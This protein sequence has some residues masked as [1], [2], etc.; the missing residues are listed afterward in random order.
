MGHTAGDVGY[1]NDGSSPL[2]LRAYSAYERA[3]LTIV[4]P[5]RATDDRAI[6]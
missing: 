5:T 1:D 3:T 4:L 6:T 2:R